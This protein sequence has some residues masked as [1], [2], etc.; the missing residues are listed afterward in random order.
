MR[1]KCIFHRPVPGCG[2]PDLSPAGEAGRPEARHAAERG[3]GAADDQ[4]RDTRHPRHQGSC[5]HPPPGHYINYL[6]IITATNYSGDS[7]AAATS[8]SPDPQLGLAPAADPA[9]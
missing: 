2:H 7:A 4:A 1:F 8:P 9:Q 5:T 3:H 6:R